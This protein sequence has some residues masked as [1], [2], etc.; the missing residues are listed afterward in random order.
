MK[1]DRIFEELKHAILSGTYTE[2]EKLPTEFELS[3]QY[4]VA[5]GTIRESLKRLEE[6]GYLE[7]IKS[8]GTFVRRPEQRN[9]D[10]VLSFLIPYP[11]YMRLAHD[12]VF[13]AFMQVFYGAVR[14]AS[15]EGWRVE[16][17]PFSRT[18]NNHDI[19]WSAM[20][21]LD[22]N[23]RLIVFNTWYHTAFRTFL[24]R[25]IK[26]GLIRCSVEPSP[27]DDCFRHWITAVIPTKADVCKAIER[28]Y[29]CGCRR[30]LN[31]NFFYDDPYNEKTI[32]Y[33]ETVRRLGLDC[34]ELNYDPFDYESQ[35]VAGRI[36]SAVHRLWE[37]THFDAFF[38]AETEGVFHFSRNLYETFGLPESVKLLMYRD[39]PSLLMMNPQISAFEADNDEI[40]YLT[41]KTLILK[42]Y[43]PAELRFHHIFHNRQSTGG[44]Y[45]PQLPKAMEPQL[46]H[47]G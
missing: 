6:E 45:V 23:S 42:P 21:H 20:E 44:E 40:G 7:R 26:V 32:A 38:S 11:D 34:L 43:S 1:R 35:G 2:G 22:E 25:R 14:A 3:A 19:D 4:A 33:R 12:A 41:A 36:I 47:Y 17:V 15:E 37:E 8:K 28:L 5:R 30:I 27:W 18:N 29:A 10:R 46:L 16:T 9:G 13:S 24:K 31:A 39:H